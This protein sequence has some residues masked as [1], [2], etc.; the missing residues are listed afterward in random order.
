MMIDRR[1]RVTCKKN[2]TALFTHNSYLQSFEFKKI[3]VFLG[4]LL[5]SSTSSILIFLKCLRLS[6]PMIDI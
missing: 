6:F 1:D 2:S 4:H 3:M 5:V